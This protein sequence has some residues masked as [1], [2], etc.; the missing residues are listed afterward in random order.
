MSN[1]TSLSLL[2]AAVVG[3][4]GVVAQQPAGGV[5]LP[6]L[7]VPEGVKAYR[8]LVY[9]SGGHERQKLDL[10]VPENVTH[11]LPLIIFVHGGAWSSGDKAAIFLPMRQGYSQRGYALA[12]INYRFSQHAIFPAQIEDCKAAVRWLRARARDYQLDPDRFGVWGPSAGGHLVALL[13]TSSDVREFDVGAHL[14][15]SSRVQCVMV[16]FGTT[17][18]TQADAHRL[19]GSTV[20]H[21][22]SDS[23]DSRLIGGLITDQANAA[24][25]RRASPITYVSKDDP[26][27]LIVHGDQDP[28]VPH[29]QSE[30]L[31]D[32]LKAAGVKVR[33]NTVKGGGH[34]VGIASP[35][36]N[37]A[38]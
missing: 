30:I 23:P 19:P 28:I 9:V 31:F 33:L 10:F 16:D 21:N 35:E 18:F 15:V 7:I 27:F 25:V 13:G 17:D 29:Y 12:T 37:R 11:S 26:P 2:F 32:A 14:E 24:K 1:P 5:A 8:D 3:C 36:L 20:V 6:P 38:S 4:S 22:S 34:G